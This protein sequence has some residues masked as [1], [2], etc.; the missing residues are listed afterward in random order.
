MLLGVGM[1]LSDGGGG[2]MVMV[3]DDVL[4]DGG[5]GDGVRWWW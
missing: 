2:D 3:S 4:G 1:V 5:G